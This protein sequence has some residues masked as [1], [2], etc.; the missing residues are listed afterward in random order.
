MNAE[1]NAA[2]SGNNNFETNFAPYFYEGYKPV[3]I[4]LFAGRIPGQADPVGVAILKK[5]GAF[6][7]SII[8]ERRG[9]YIFAE[10]VFLARGDK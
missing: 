7:S 4:E 10:P 9:G 2:Q 3:R 8:F 6:Y 1:T 5:D